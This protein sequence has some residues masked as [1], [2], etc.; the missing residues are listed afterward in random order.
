MRLSEAFELYRMDVISFRNQSVK[1]EENHFVA[2]KSI[3]N[4]L[5]DI[6]VSSLTFD[7]VRNWKCDL[8]KNRSDA[9]VRNYIIKLRV[10]LKYLQV[11]GVPCLNPEE[12]PVPKRTDKVPI[13]LS[14]EQVSH[15]IKSTRRIKNKCIISLLYASGIRISELCSLDR[16]SIKERR[17]TIIGKGGRARLCFIDERTETLIDLYIGTRIDN[18]KALF[19]SDSGKRITPGVIQE[20]FKSLRKT[21][22]IDCHPHTLRHSFATNLLQTNTNLY[23]VSKML[24]HQQLTT[25]Q[26]YLHAVDY[27]LHKVY[28]EHHTI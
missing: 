10:V 4:Y 8:E 28:R 26:Q 22:K 6:E 20:T 24:G 16:D 15:L 23:Y 12:V 14:K 2:M 9:T 3:T 7:M 25:T 18:N 27:D 1:T 19:L 5:G 11:K 17:F 21:S 13:Y